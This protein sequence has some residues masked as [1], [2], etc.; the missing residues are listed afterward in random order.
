MNTRIGKIALIPWLFLAFLLF[1]ATAN[2]A[3]IKIAAYNIEHMDRI[4]DE[5]LNIAMEDR[6][7]AIASNI[8][9]VD[10]DILALEEAP[11]SEEQVKL[12]V[13]QFL[14]G[15]YN[16]YFEK[17]RDQSL[18]LLIKKDINPTCSVTKISRREYRKRWKADIDEDGKQEEW[19]YSFS[20]PPLE[21]DLRFDCGTL[22]MIVLHLKS[23]FAKSVKAKRLA[24]YKLIAQVQRLREIIGPD[25]T[26]DI[27]ILGDMNDNPGFEDDPY[28]RELG[29]D[30]I[31]ELIGSPPNKL[32]SS[33]THI[34]RKWRF[35]C[36]HYNDTTKD[37]DVSWIDRILFT[38]ALNKE[39]ITYKKNS[40]KIYHEL[41]NPLASDHIPVSA[42]FIVGEE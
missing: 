24:R 21:V 2:S 33:L 9:A 23:K 39:P 34:D 16:V 40:G 22:K 12:F 18:A 6:C 15:K 28:E 11:G 1:A 3:E 29:I 31:S 37:A 7:H 5:S 26:K 25:M 36:I 42:V 13:D 19:K 30:G 8:K 35:T 20:R 4:I 41:L 10:P 14:D 32:K 27:I 17:S 38:K